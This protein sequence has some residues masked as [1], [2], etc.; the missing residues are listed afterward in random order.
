MRTAFLSNNA[1]DLDLLNLSFSRFLGCDVPFRRIDGV[2]GRLNNIAFALNSSKAYVRL[3]IPGAKTTQ[4]IE[5]VFLMVKSSTV[6]VSSLLKK[7]L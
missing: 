3:E 6:P 7:I 1:A 2:H 4:C 5:I